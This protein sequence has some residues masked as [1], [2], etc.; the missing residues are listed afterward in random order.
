[1]SRPLIHF[2]NE[3]EELLPPSQLSQ[4]SVVEFCQCHQMKKALIKESNNFFNVSQIISG[5]AGDWSEYLT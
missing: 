5:I 4:L 3:A 1:M 2:Y